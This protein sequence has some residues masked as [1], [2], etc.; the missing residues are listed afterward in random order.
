[1]DK[2]FMQ[3]KSGCKFMLFLA[4]G[5]TI[6]NSTVI[7]VNRIVFQVDL[8]DSTLSW[9]LGGQLYAELR[10]VTCEVAIVQYPH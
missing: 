3:V 5:T 2:F 4:A 10:D 6:L 9:R 1:M 7:I 8:D